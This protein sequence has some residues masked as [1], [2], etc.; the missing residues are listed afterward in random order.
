[1]SPA[2]IVGG[3]KRLRGD[4]CR[5]F[6]F[7]GTERRCSRFLRASGRDRLTDMDQKQRHE[8]SWAQRFSTHSLDR[9]HGQRLHSS[10][11]FDLPSEP[12]TGL[13]TLLEKLERAEARQLGT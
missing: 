1:M 5:A 2:R 6:G 7:Q 9:V 4:D 3:R 11:A 8:E 13:Q 10:P 12:D